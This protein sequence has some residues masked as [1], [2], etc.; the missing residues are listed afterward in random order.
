MN[1]ILSAP[2]QR[3]TIICAFRYRYAKDFQ[4][5]SQENVLADLKLYLDFCLLNNTHPSRIVI[6][7]DILLPENYNNYQV[8]YISDEITFLNVIKDHISKLGIN[9]NFIFIFSGHGERLNGITY[10]VIPSAQRRSKFVSGYQLQ[11]IFQN[12]LPLKVNC[13]WIL[14]TC[15]SGGLIKLNYQIKKDKAEKSGKYFDMGS[16]RNVLCFH[17][18]R[19]KQLSGMF[20]TEN[21]YGSVFSHFLLKYFRKISGISKED[22]LTIP[23]IINTIS[24]Q[25]EGQRRISIQPEHMPLVQSTSKNLKFNLSSYI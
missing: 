7:T 13:L 5:L 2:K 22:E 18:S 20:I 25:I 1:D 21:K 16:G 4:D 14:D 6:L 24:G 9:S 11:K 12:Y 19:K 10:L 23:D 17:S 8:Y 3:L 15:Y